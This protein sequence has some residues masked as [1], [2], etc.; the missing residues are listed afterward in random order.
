MRSRTLIV[1]AGGLLAALGSLIALPQIGSA[2]TNPTS[3]LTAAAGDIACDPTD[4]NFNAG[5]GTANYC[6]ESQTAAL[7]AGFKPSVV[8]ALGDTQYN[9]ATTSDFAASYNGSWG[10]FLP[11]TQSV[12]G[13][14]E[15][16]SYGAAGFFSY[17]SGNWGANNTGYRS[18]D[19]PLDTSTWHVVVLNSECSSINKGVGCAVGSPQYNWLQNDL[20]ANAADQCTLVVAHRPRWA[21]DSWFSA[22]IQPLVDLLG[23]YHADLFLAGH[24]HNYERFAA[25]TASGA[26]SSSGITEIVVGTGGQD[27]R[28]FGTTAKNSVA[29]FANVFG[30][31]RLSLYSGKY[32]WNYVADPSTPASDHGTGYCH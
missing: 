26:A 3:V 1:T 6:H 5:A 17:F 25:Q 28:G 14:H 2:A 18:F 9:R 11:Q 29:R 30:V 23:Q 31:L 27:K 13:N 15:Y 12:V 7:I 19:I 10:A 20:Q 8:F 32:V 24:A 16:M 4:A 21:S 22:D